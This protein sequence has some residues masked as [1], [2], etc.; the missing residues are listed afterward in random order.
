MALLQEGTDYTESAERWGGVCVYVGQAGGRA[1]SA[2]RWGNVC[3]LLLL[4][5]FL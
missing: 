2:E 3:V 4:I 5:A 1:E